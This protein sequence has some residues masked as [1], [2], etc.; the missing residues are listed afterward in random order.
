[1]PGRVGIASFPTDLAPWNANSHVQSGRLG[2]LVHRSPRP[3][4]QRAMSDNTGLVP[5][6]IATAVTP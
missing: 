2:D 3:S 6:D 1:M 5:T 4:V